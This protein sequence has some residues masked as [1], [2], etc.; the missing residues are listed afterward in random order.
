MPEHDETRKDRRRRTSRNLRSRKVRA[1]L[2]S[3]LVLGVG[4]T[5]TL[6]AW[7]DSEH[8]TGTLEAGSF[9]LLG[10][11]DGADF[12][13]STAEAPHQLT[14]TPNADQLF[15]STSTYS[16]FSVRTGETSMAG[17]VRLTAQTGNT[18]GLGEFLTYSVN[19][20]DD[21]AN[22]TEEGFNNGDTLVENQVL[23]FSPDEAQSVSAN[24]GSPV[25]YCLELTLPVGTPDSA[26][27]MSVSPQ[28]EFQGTS[29]SE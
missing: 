15:P 7:N 21:P 24:G 1:V 9:A 18:E 20:M 19:T 14:F 10:S 28:W 25:H 5:I 16:Y 22:C 13:P 6:A 8:A 29:V 26:Q 4:A 23:A 12:T 3:G 2:A 27:G 17:V 11:A